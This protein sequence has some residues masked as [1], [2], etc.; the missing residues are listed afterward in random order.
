MPSYVFSH[1]LTCFS[2]AALPSCEVETDCASLGCAVCDLLLSHLTLRPTDS[3]ETEQALAAGAE[4]EEGRGGC[5]ETQEQQDTRLGIVIAVQLPEPA[6][7]SPR[8]IA[9]PA[10]LCHMG[11]RPKLPEHK[12]LHKNFN[13]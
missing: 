1:S 8:G 4:S 10:K 6:L 2:S 13:C 11:T 12:C 9:A 3:S 7:C 5:W